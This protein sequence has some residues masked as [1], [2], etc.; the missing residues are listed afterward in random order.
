MNVEG[1]RQEIIETLSDAGVLL[2]GHVGLLPQTAERY[3]LRGKHPQEAE[4]IFRDAL[5]LYKTGVFSVIS[6]MRARV[7]S[8][9]TILFFA[10][11]MVVH[12][13]LLH[14]NFHVLH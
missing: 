3:K 13:K 7:N 8:E 6:E 12:I 9:K 5:Q 1:Y 2:V 4:Q 14:L 10:H 11:A